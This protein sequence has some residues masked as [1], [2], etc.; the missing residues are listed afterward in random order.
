MLSVFLQVSLFKDPVVARMRPAVIRS[1]PWDF[2]L[3]LQTLVL[4]F[5]PLEDSS[6]KLLMVK[7]VFLVVFTDAR[8]VS[9]M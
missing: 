5:E 3:V 8:R 1:C 7:T 6:I 9:E 4:R 2:S